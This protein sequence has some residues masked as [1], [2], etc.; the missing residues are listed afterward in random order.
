MDESS[1]TGESIPVE[2]EKG[3]K[4]ISG[5]INK[6]GAFSFKAEKVGEETTISQIIKLVEEASNSKAPISK[7]ADKVSGIFVPIVIIIA[8]IA[9]ITWIIVG[10]GIENAISIGIAVLVIS[11]P[12]ALGLATPVAIMVGIGKGA[13]NG[14]LIKSAESLELL[15]LV[16]TVVFDKTGTITI[17]KPEV[18]DIIPYN[19]EN[20][21]LLSIAYTLEEKSEHPLAEAI[22]KKAKEENIET[23]CIEDFFVI[24]GKGIKGQIE[25]ENY[26]VGNLSYMKEYKVEMK[27]IEKIGNNLAVQGKTPLYFAKEG[28]IIGIIAVKDNIKENSKKAIE[29]LKNMNLEV[30]MLTGDNKL[31]AEAIKKDIGIEKV[32]AEVIP[33]Q[34][35]ETICNIQKEN[36]KVAFVGDGINDSPAITRAD[37]GIAIGSGTDIAI[38]S[39]D[40]VLIKNDI[41]DVVTAIELSKCV[42]KNIKINLFWAFFYNIIGI[43]L[44]AGVFYNMLG[45]KLSPMFG[46]VAMSLSSICVVVNALRIKKFRVK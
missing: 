9:T 17:G 26:L 12:C 5:T 39:A 44:A 43:P 33:Q 42:I 1:I 10:S 20:T 7:I 21:K 38:D 16:D 23:M 22:I 28:K 25:N 18:T 19:I 11:C 46:A 13:E 14:I 31:T 41:L 35:D 24:S 32:I 4:V 34:K 29:K 40:I 3:S 8:L 36:K 45:W 37:V 2:K 6:M 30:I 27:E 15:H